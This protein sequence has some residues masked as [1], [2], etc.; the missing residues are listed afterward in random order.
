LNLK[1]WSLFVADLLLDLARR[2][3]AK[4]LVKQLK[5][6]IP[7]PQPLMRSASPLQTTP[8]ADATVAVL[9]KKG[10]ILASSLKPILQGLGARIIENR[11]SNDLLT[12]LVIDVTTL[13]EVHDLG[14]LYDTI[15]P[16]LNNMRESGRIVLVG[17]SRTAC[18]T[19][20]EHA[21]FSALRG[22]VKS[23]SKEV[24]RRGTTCN[25]LSTDLETSDPSHIVWPLTFLLSQRSAYISGQS[26]DL[27]GAQPKRQDGVLTADD[28]CW[29]RPLSEKTAL[30][31]G[32]A[33]G[34]GEAICR[35]LAAEGARVIGL[36]RPTE[37]AALE[38]LMSDIGGIPF[39]YDL[40]AHGAI[41]QIVARLETEI[42]SVDI[43]VHN[44]GIT[45]DKT[46]QRMPRDYWD[47]TLEVNL[48]AP[49]NLTASL[50]LSDTGLIRL[51]GPGGRILFISSISGIAGNAGQT[52]YAAAKA[53]L[54]G[55]TEAL[56][57]KLSGRDITVNAIAP[58]FI[59]TKMTQRMPVSVREVARRLNALGQGGRPEDVAEAVLFLVAP[60][61]EGISGS[62]LRVCGHSIVGS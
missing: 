35:R 46:L 31:T 26:L 51:M 11:E 37:R 13:R 8:L 18:R 19:V 4:R 23:L 24:G 3:L 28:L 34:I 45:R 55:Y 20:E 29:V 17:K 60:G 14:F 16:N 6:P 12:S 52:N 21:V 33:Q 32:A 9:G 10:S 59:E 25:L 58:G 1:I 49:I 61:A 48:K 39:A 7:L 38:T 62:V 44:A 41:E 36:D 30:V 50:V 57:R 40:T 2:P 53:G 42:G 5:L 47:D 54:I 22:F 43:I 27:L 15:K 56:A